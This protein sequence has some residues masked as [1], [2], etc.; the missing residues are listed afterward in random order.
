MS[1]IPATGVLLRLFQGSTLD[2]TLTF[3]TTPAKTTLKDLTD[4]AAALMVRKDFS[5]ASPV[6]LSLTDIVAIDDP[7]TLSGLVIGDALGTV[8]IYATDEK[9]AAIALE[10]FRQS[11]E[12]GEIM[13][14]GVWDLELTNPDGETSR[15]V[16]GP[17][18]FSPEVTHA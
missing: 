7:P 14:T 18:E 6:L 12:D 9:M 11:C 17:V 1:V 8:R 10:G 4:Y 3:Y 5:P 13:G 16:M 2:K 15:Y